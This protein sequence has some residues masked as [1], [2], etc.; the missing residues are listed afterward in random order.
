MGYQRPSATTAISDSWQGHKNR[1]PPSQEPGTD[2]PCAY[3]SSVVAPAEGVV[4]EV[5]TSNSDATGRFVAIDLADG[6]RVRSL[7]L[8]RILVTSGQ[9]VKRGQEVAKSGASANGR[10]WGVGA[11]VH[12]TL[13]SSHRYV[14]GPNGTLDF[15]RYVGSDSVIAFSQTVANEQNYLNAARGEK[16]VVDG[17]KGDKTTAAIKR[18]Q[19][20]LRSRGWYSG[21]IDGDWGGGTQSGHE[22]AYAEWVAATQAPP[23]PQFHTATVADLGTLTYVNGLQKVAHLYGYGKGQ[24]QSVWMDNRW[25]GGSAAGFQRFLDQNYGGSLAAWLRAKYGYQGNDQWGPV[26]AAAA[27]RAENANWRAL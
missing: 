13:W 18:Y 24:A 22:K 16:L 25:G 15:E 19:E 14:F 10:D 3:G 11:H 2:Y 7:H 4:I 21:P 8:S 12:Q 27:A 17:R 26:M 9:R 23:S 1:R 6:R 20:Y 5:K